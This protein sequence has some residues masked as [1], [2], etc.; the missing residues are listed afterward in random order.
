MATRSCVF[1]EASSGPLWHLGSWNRWA[2]VLIQRGYPYLIQ[3]IFIKLI[4]NAAS[5]VTTPNAP[6]R[7]WRVKDGD[8]A[9]QEARS[10]GQVDL[11]SG[12]FYDCCHPSPA[13]FHPLHVPIFPAPIVPSPVLLQPIFGRRAKET[14]SLLITFPSEE[15]H[16]IQGPDQEQCPTIR[17][18]AVFYSQLNP[19]QQQV[20]NS[21]GEGANKAL[22]F[23]TRTIQNFYLY[24]VSTAQ[25]SDNC[26]APTC[27]SAKAANPEFE[28]LM[29]RV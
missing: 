1:P 28:D 16:R 29:L 21:K 14:L 2:I 23:G 22:V 20:K 5:L 10:I 6:F 24:Y 4:P 8:W 25:P 7:A 27:H 18:E 17:V 15:S 26:W 13:L 19:K 3:G 12:D 9:D 11:V